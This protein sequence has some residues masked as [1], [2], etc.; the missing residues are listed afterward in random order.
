MEK[1]TF[2]EEG[3]MLVGWF[4]EFP[5]YKTQG[6]TIEELEENLLDI[7]QGEEETDQCR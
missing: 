1:F 4:D 7:Y 2:F 3:G 6:K 5:D